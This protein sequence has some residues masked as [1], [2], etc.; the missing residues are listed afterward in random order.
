MGAGCKIR[1][2]DCLQQSK[3]YFLYIKRSR[4]ANRTWIISNRTSEIRTY[5]CPVLQT[6][7]PVFGALLYMTKIKMSS[8]FFVW[9]LHSWEYQFWTSGFWT[10]T[11]LWTIKKK[12]LKL[13]S[14]FTRFP[15]GLTGLVALGLLQKPTR[16]W[17]FSAFLP[18]FM[19]VITNVLYFENFSI[20]GGNQF[21]ELTN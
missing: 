21:V 3:I 18:L 7:R 11:L 14:K 9:L 17:C 4:L 8:L 5:L 12:N 19:L 13:V 15:S 2:K 6:G 10:F 1:F 20:F 16:S